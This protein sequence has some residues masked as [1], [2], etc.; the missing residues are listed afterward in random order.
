MKTRL[1][2]HSNAGYDF[3]TEN[4]RPEPFLFLIKLLLTSPFT[5]DFSRF[6][7]RLYLLCKTF[8]SC[9]TGAGLKL[10]SSKSRILLE[11][12]LLTAQHV[13]IT[14]AAEPRAR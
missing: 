8:L 1:M 9:I 11:A 3:Q 7:S 4:L 6:C 10:V 12:T 5:I 14:Q 2:K 13:I